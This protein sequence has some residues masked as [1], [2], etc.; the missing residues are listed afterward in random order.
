MLSVEWKSS[1]HWTHLGKKSLFSQ[2]SNSKLVIAGKA[3]IQYQTMGLP[4]LNGIQPAL[5]LLITLVL[6]LLWRIK[7]SAM[8]KG[9]QGPQISSSLSPQDFWA[10]CF[11]FRINRWRKRPETL[12]GILLTH[13]SLWR[14]SL[15]LCGLAV[16]YPLHAKIQLRERKI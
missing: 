7:M 5:M 8:N 16:Y 2:T 14:K 1:S 12:F 4:D 13:W 11:C 3:L 10:G 15:T 6:F 9:L